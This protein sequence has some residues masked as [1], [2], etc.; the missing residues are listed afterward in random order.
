MASGNLDAAEPEEGDE[1]IEPV[2]IAVY[3]LPRCGS[4]LSGDGRT[5]HAAGGRAP[6]VLAV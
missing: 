6:I 2:V 4:R 3:P 5:L 1:S